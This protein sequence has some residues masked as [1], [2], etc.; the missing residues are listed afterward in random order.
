MCG[1]LYRI[2][3]GL[4]PSPPSGFFLSAFYSWQFPVKPATCEL[5]SKA[6][7]KVAMRSRNQ[8]RREIAVTAA[9]NFRNG[10][11]DCSAIPSHPFLRIA[12]YC[13]NNSKLFGL[14]EL[15]LQSRFPKIE[16]R[17]DQLLSFNFE[18]SP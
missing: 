1:G 15:L 9:V 3:S 8:C 17:T 13:S 14:Y 10:F 6:G 2:G 4:V 7:I 16:Y 5:P 11:P 18:N 12:V